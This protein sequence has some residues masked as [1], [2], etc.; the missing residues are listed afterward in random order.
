MPESRPVSSLLALPGAVAIAVDGTAVAAGADQAT[1]VAA[2][3]GDPVGEQRML[4]AGRAIVDLSDRGVITVSGPDRLTWL[5]SLTTQHLTGLA[6]R[7][8]TQSL[9]LSPKGHV[10]H[11]LHLV[12][13]GE[14]AYGHAVLLRARTA[15]RTRPP[16]APALTRVAP[17]REASRTARGCS[18][19]MSGHN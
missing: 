7:T 1:T 14:Q 3:Y 19:V 4:V 8:S 12:D 16:E 18:R 5:H 15:A 10:E 13:D 6:P 11:D 9:V 2:H 17:R